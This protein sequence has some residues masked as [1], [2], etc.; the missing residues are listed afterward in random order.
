MDAT[1]AASS[2]SAAAAPPTAADAAW[3][4]FA[5]AAAPAPPADA[6]LAERI[7]MLARFASRSSA[8]FLDVV[9]SRQAEGGEYAFL[10]GGEG[11]AFFECELAA[12]RAEAARA[13]PDGLAAGF[14]AVLESLSGAGGTIKAAAGWLLAAGAPHSHGL[15]LA[16][17]QRA[18]ELPDLA[19]RLHLLYMA[20]EA[21]LQRRAPPSPG[22]R[23]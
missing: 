14:R 4:S 13:L 3:A 11:A 19:R 1:W 9:R 18:A 22:A 17:A 2:S 6:A 10:F 21:L 7:R 20:H 8:D 16:M 12:A 23:V 5:A 15:A